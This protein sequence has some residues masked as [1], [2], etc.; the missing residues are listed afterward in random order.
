MKKLI[1]F[2]GLFLIAPL[3]K[4]DVVNP[5]VPP[6]VSDQFLASL[7]KSLVVVGVHTSHDKNKVEALDNLLQFGHYQGSYIVGLNYGLIGN[8]DSIRNTYGASANV[9]PIILQN[10][11]MNP[12]LKAFLSH[13]YITPR[14]S[15]D[16]DEGRWVKSYTYGA[17]FSF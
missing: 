2:V 11:P 14:I 13:A 8:T 4:A 12:D 6:S 5:M 3:V 10:V 15:W 16:E 1:V 17:V 9:M 7:T